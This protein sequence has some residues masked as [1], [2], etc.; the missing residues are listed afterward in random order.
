MEEFCSDVIKKVCLN[1]EMAEV[2]DL[3][4][5]LEQLIN[6]FVDLMTQ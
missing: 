3:T 5:G 2:D 4:N 1:H 6:R